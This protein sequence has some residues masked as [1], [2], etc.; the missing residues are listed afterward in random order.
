MKMNLKNINITLGTITK[1]TLARADCYQER[2]SF[3]NNRAQTV[4]AGI[5]EE[6]RRKKESVRERGRERDSLIL[7][8][9]SNTGEGTQKSP[10][11]PHE[12]A[13]APGGHRFGIIFSMSLQDDLLLHLCLGEHRFG[14]IFSMNLQDDL[15]LY[16][17]LVFNEQSNTGEGAQ[18]S[19][20]PPHEVAGAPI[21]ASNSQ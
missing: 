3:R 17:G 20:G 6:G 7:K 15:L 18:K 9:K 8:E 11:P 4:T 16:L 19:P 14:I 1:A 21:L 5:S 12:V 13:G 10:G 2:A